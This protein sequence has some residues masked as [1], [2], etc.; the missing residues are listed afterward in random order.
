[1]LLFDEFFGKWVTNEN[2]EFGELELNDDV[3]VMN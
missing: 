2:V 3:V 1:M